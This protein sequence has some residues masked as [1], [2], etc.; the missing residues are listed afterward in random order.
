MKIIRRSDF[1]ASPWKNGGGVTH[2]AIRVPAGGVFRWRVSVAQIETSGPFS[3]FAG[4]ER[5]MVLLEGNGVALK[6]GDGGERVLC[7]VGDM[8]EFDGARATFCELK[9]G[10]CVD[11]NLMVAR[12][13]GPSGARVQRLDAPMTLMRASG[14]STLVFPLDAPV[15]LDVAGARE[16]LERWDLAVLADAGSLSPVAGA[17][18][19]FIA[20]VPD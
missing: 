14:R 16:V 4:Y 5:F 2:E 8:A 6:F 1:V 3:D 15:A 17:A 18:Q 10:A 11:L 19:A 9:A 7:Q 13:A 12:G 20:S